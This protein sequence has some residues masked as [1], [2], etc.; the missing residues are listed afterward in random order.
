MITSVSTHS[1]KL[2]KDIPF[3]KIHD[4]KYEIYSGDFE[5][6]SFSLE[7]TFS[8]KIKRFR[9][10]DCKW[11]TVESRGIATELSP[12][13]LQMANGQIIQANHK[14]GI[15]EVSPKFPNSLFW[16]FNAKLAQPIVNYTGP[17][18]SKLVT[19]AAS[20]LHLDVPLALL[21]SPDAG[22][23]L[24]R[25]K[26]PFTA[27]ACFTDHCDFD[28]LENLKIQRQFFKTHQ[29]KITKGFFLN[30]FS[31]RADNASWELH[32]EE[33]EKWVLDGHELAYHS[34]SQSIKTDL[35]SLSDFFKFKAPLNAI[36]VWID[37][38]YQPYN[39]SLYKKMGL[40]EYDFSNQLS[41]Q[42]IKTLWNYIDTGTSAKGVINQL[43]PNHFTL[44]SFWDGV[45][46]LGLKKSISL[47]VK[48][49]FFH[50]FNDDKK[51]QSYKLL[52]VDV[53]AFFINKKLSALGSLMKHAFNILPA[54][55][56]VLLFWNSKKT[57]T[58]PLAIYTP[59]LFNH[60]ISG[61]TFKVFQTLEMVDFKASLCKANIDLLCEEKGVFIAHTYFSVPLSYHHGRLLKD[62]NTIDKY[63][64]ANFVYL[65]KK[66]AERSIWNPTLSEFQ[67]YIDMY[68]KVSF[69][70]D[71]KGLIFVN[72][73]PAIGAR[74]VSV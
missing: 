66:I 35:E 50:Y 11:K 10:H 72:G 44:K 39:F 21:L 36:K 25:S 2:Q 15:W 59:L 29:I 51:I 53:K 64:N 27:I 63:V 6:Q 55:T 34:L 16:H 46:G 17:E 40:E 58:Y 61:H 41:S 52:A 1:S 67:N 73:D 47:M 19:S 8:Q 56:S 57:N 9:D 26:F 38:G 22:I 28:T 5:Q 33:L 43:N 54:F 30:Q 49:M 24:S 68:K 65:S 42:H 14:C 31:T 12:K 45:E 48:N 20:D 3:N 62:Q 7:I 18:N 71:E 4:F 13:I 70:C 23:E 74:K 37:H 60:D 32:K 69:D